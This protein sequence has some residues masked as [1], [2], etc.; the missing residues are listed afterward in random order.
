MPVTEVDGNIQAARE[1]LNAAVSGLIDPQPRTV[2]LDGNRTETAWLDSAYVQLRASTGGQNVSDKGDS[3]PGRLP[4]WVEAVDLLVEIDTE[5]A[6][7]HPARP[8]PGV[9]PT[10]VLRLEAI[11]TATYRPQDTAQVSRWAAAVRG[12]THRI[13]TLLDP[14]SIKHISAPCPQCGTATVWRRDGTGEV[15]RQ[16]ALQLVTDQGCTCMACRTHWEP[17]RYLFLCRLLG[18]DLPEGVLE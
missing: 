11:D 15:V 13:R 10:T 14:E 5:V 16:P 9:K 6:V 18:F 7:W 8:A 4:I 17:A 2:Y 12:W 1:R 3:R